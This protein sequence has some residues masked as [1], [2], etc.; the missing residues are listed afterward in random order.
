MIPRRTLFFCL[1]LLTGIAQGEQR[2]A[3]TSS[4]IVGTPDPP[5]DYRVEQAYPNLSFFHAVE[6][7]PLGATGR[8]AVLDVTG[9]LLTFEDSPGCDQAD[10]AL[11]IKPL[12]ENFRSAFSF[13]LHPDFDQNHHVFVVYASNPVA[14]PD[15]SRLSR[16]TMT[17]SDP[18]VIDPASEEVLLTWASGGHNGC[19]IRFDHEGLLYFSAGDGARPYPPDEY[20]VGQDLS[21]LRSTI[22][23]ID[24]DRP[25][26]KR[27]YSIPKDNPFIDTPGARPEIWAFG[28]RNPWRYCFVP[29]TNRILCGD[30]GWELWE[31]VFDVRRGGNYGWS[32]FEGPQPIRSDL[33][34]GPAPL[35]KPLVSYPHTVGQSITGGVV[36]QGSALPELDGTYLYGDYVTGLLWGLKTDDPTASWNP[37]LAETGMPIITFGQT[38]DGEPLIVSYDGGIYRLVRNELAGKPNTQFPRRLSQTGLF[39]STSKLTAAPGVYRYQP[40]AQSWQGGPRSEFLIAVPGAKSIQIKKA[41]RQWKF[42][43]GTVFVRTFLHGKTRLETQLL[44]FDGISWLPYSYLWNEAQTDAELVEASGLTHSFAVDV[45]GRTETLD[46]KVHHRAQCQTCHSRERGGGIGFDLDN[47]VTIGDRGE[48]DLQRMI[49]LGILDKAPAKWWNVKRMVDPHDTQADLDSRARSY[50]SANCVHCHQRGGGGTVPL[51]LLYVNDTDAINAVNFLPTQGTFGIED[52]KVIAPGD[53]SRSILF[54]RMA[55][56][57]SGH[58]PKIWSRDNDLEGLELIHDWIASMPSSETARPSDTQAALVDFASLAFG[59]AG[60]E[61]RANAA[62]DVSKKRD[63][64][65]GGLYERFLP[66]AERKKR[67]G[68]NIDVDQILALPGNA[69]SGRALLMDAQSRQC[70]NCHRVKG[71]GRSVGPDLDLIATKRS[72]E[73][74]LESILNPS[75]AIDQLYQTHTV[76]TDDGDIVSGLMIETKP[77]N[78]TIR[79]ADGKDHVVSTDRIQSQKTSPISIMPTG[80]AA[81]LTAQE[82]ADILAFLTSLK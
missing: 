7:A 22:C 17:M 59:S 25:D 78:L 24:V 8:M 81:E 41:K 21:D 14:K 32:L 61:Q 39:E 57:S 80:L 68:E 36:Y 52:A 29:G 75:K 16:F 51:D 58:M 31:L 42:P 76:L 64:V 79:T 70:V 34:R 45:E 69:Q 65:R 13:A 5:K 2:V 55:T 46:W 54:Y 35:S 30:V 49:E 3:W 28:F 73:H 62:R 82:L 40:I 44:H 19:S 63:A 12:H 6:I 71:T 15:G 1:A 10:L 38:R 11:E 33:A 26:G 77:T 72:K 9:R 48:T 37:V 66:K 43:E 50:L 60:P 23:R 27:L 20:D 47:L 56:S 4:Q 53:P 74:L 18:P 67:L